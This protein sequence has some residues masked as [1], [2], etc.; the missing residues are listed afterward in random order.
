MVFL[1][2]PTLQQQFPCGIED[3]NGESPVKLAT[4]LVSSKLRLEPDRTVVLID[5][6]YLL[7]VFFS[8]QRALLFSMSSGVSLTRNPYTITR[9]GARLSKRLV[10]V[11]TEVFCGDEPIS[12]RSVGR[13]IGRLAE[14]LF[15]DDREPTAL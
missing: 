9:D 11:F 4:I 6:D 13:L 8:T 7:A 1:F 5:E 3:E 2:C 15:A 14:R 10:I 12:T